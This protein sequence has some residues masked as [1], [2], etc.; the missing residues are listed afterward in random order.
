VILLGR[1][2]RD[3]ASWRARVALAQRMQAQVI[4]DLKMPAAFPTD[5]PLHAGPPGVFLSPACIDALRA[6]DVVLALDWYDLAGTLKQALGGAPLDARIVN[7]SPDAYVHRGWSMDYQGLAPAD[8][9]LMCE[10]D[11]VVSA[12]LERASQHAPRALA[13]KSALPPAP[14]ALSMR[15][16]ADAFNAAAGS[17]DVCLTRV[18]LGWHGAYRDFRAPLDYIGLE[19]GGGVGAGPGITVGAA[20]ALRGS[21]RTPVAIMGDGDFLMGVTALWTAAHYRLPCVIVVANNR[22][23]YNDEVH[24]ERVARAR[25][26]PVENK[27]IG[28][29]IDEPDIDL[30]AMA[31]AQGAK[32]FGP[33]A[34]PTA[35]APA[36][37]G[38]LAEA[39]AGH[40]AVVDVRVQPGYDANPSGAA[41]H[42]RGAQ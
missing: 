3:E 16:L 22:S 38:A 29:R 41:S 42:R 31:R 32:A 24:Q 27:W 14:D 18:P 35:L 36:L 5:H 15:T 34:T 4:T 21:G 28:Q 13:P 10:P 7:V 37:E 40:V 2:A 19:G 33:I 20:L 6:A 25:G 39:D 17:R 12:L 9:Y 8:D 1:T 11:V 26:R 23:F 30:G